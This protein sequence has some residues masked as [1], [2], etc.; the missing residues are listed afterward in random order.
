MHHQPCPYPKGVTTALPEWLQES[1]GHAESSTGRKALEARGCHENKNC[2]P[3]DDTSNSRHIQ[4]IPR[5]FLRVSLNY[6]SVAVSISPSLL[7]S[8]YLSLVLCHVR[9]R[10]LRYDASTK[11]PMTTR[12]PTGS[13]T[14]Q[15]P[16]LRQ[17]FPLPIV[18][19]AT[20]TRR[21]RINY[22]LLH[23]AYP[24]RYPRGHDTAIFLAFSRNTKGCRGARWSL[25]SA[26]IRSIQGRIAWSI[27]CVS[28][29]QARQARPQQQQQSSLHVGRTQER[30]TKHD[31]KEN[32]SQGAW[33]HGELRLLHVARGREPWRD[34]LLPSLIFYL[35]VGQRG[36]ERFCERQGCGFCAL[37]SES[38]SAAVARA[39]RS[40]GG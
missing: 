33:S 26:L 3:T 35:Y 9:R 14:T 21:V 22:H 4:E 32:R 7:L 12:T 39:R 27:A 5:L 30:S 1:S 36:N 13:N 34:F 29:L 10:F 31:R 2:H 38:E 8:N 37:R 15:Q 6:S 17:Y 25:T 20:P 40:G 23:S 28:W 18:A 24:S 11:S 16:H 19:P